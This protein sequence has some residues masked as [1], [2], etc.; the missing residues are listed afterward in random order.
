M[1]VNFDKETELKLNDELKIFVDEIDSDD[2]RLMDYGESF[3]GAKSNDESVEGDE[4]ESDIEYKSG[5]ERPKTITALNQWRRNQKLSKFRKLFEENKHFFDLTCDCCSK[6]FKSYEESRAHYLK[7]HNN[8]KG[9]IKCCGHKLQF[10]FQ[11]VAHLN[12]HLG[13][14]K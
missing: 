9:Y 3:N 5:D 10:R 1:K 7:E 4:A 11:I 13:T 8:S 12:R 14:Y 6:I 2:D